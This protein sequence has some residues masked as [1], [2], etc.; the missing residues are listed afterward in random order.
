LEVLVTA[1]HW[2]IAFLLLCLVIA[3]LA[4]SPGQ[5]HSASLGWDKLNHACAFAAMAFA[6]MLG[7]R[8]RLHYRR[9]VALGLVAYGAAIEIAQRFVPGRSCEWGDLLADSVG[10]AVGMLLATRK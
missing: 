9:Y 3:Y 6:A 5:P 8:N 10:I 7:F 4:L 1:R 2:R